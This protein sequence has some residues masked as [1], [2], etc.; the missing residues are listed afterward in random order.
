MERLE[1]A[2]KWKEQM[3]HFVAPRDGEIIG[4][5]ASREVAWW[6]CSRYGLKPYPLTDDTVVSLEA[7]ESGAMNRPQ[8]AGG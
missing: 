3:I 5:A 7:S 1:I 4:K 2:L 8:F 6:L